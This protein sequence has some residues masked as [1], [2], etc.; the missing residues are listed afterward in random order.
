MH[1]PQRLTK[2]DEIRIIST[3]RKI[4]LSELKP[5]LNWITDQ[6]FTYSFGAH[7]FESFHQFAGTD[8]QRASD[9]ITALED[10]NVKAI[11]CARGGY[12]SIR[13]MPFLQN[14]DPTKNLKWVIGYSDVTVIHAW[15]MSKSI[16]S[17]HA[18]M[19]INVKDNTPESLKS[20]IECL[21]TDE[22]R[23]EWTGEFSNEIDVQGKIVGGNLS[24][25]YSL[26]GTPWQYKTDGCILFFEDLDEYLYHIDRMLQTLQYGGWFS[27]IKAILVGGMS[28]MNDNNIPFGFSAKESILNIT[29]TLN[30]PIVFDFPVG[31]QNNNLAVP[32]GQRARLTTGTKNQLIIG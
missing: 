28:D 18:T 26:N 14:I 9:L 29:N 7:I 16:M 3:A 30:I 23:Y 2:G 13:L 31:H 21:T 15:L 24:M 4:T 11:W 27:N 19:P 5:A 8:K 6:G 10:E 17:L 12:G 32:I 20:L 1:I 25:L 22:V